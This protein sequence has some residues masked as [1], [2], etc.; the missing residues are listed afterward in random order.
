M[1][2][3]FDALQ[4]SESDRSGSGGAGLSA[5]TMLATDLLHVAE[6]GAPEEHDRL[7]EFPTRRPV[8]Q[9]EARL[10]CITAPESLAAEKFRF[11]AVRLRQ[12]QQNQ[13][14][15]TLLLTSTTSEE[16]KSM[17]SCNLAFA[18]AR[19]RKQKV[20]LIDGDLRRPVL[21]TRL[22]LGN[23]PGTV[24]WLQAETGSIPPIY[25]LEETGVWLLPAGSPPPNPIELIQSP[26]VAEL[27]RQMYSAFDWI[28]IDSPPLLPLADTSIWS[29]L[30]EACLLVTRQGVTE[31]RKLM[32]G[33]EI[34]DKSKIVGAILNS[35]SN[36]DHEDYY[37]RYGSPSQP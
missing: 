8:P 16:G 23:L 19:K 36:A 1:S 9:P 18:L 15:K 25:R 14:I 7:E 31:K 6:S 22:G 33:L 26:R 2:R 4:R 29:K 35:C 24:E 13:G 3:I 12:L 20:L 37:R 28:L 11:L 21:A 30:V 5:P 17:V 10:V 32:S 27:L 34:V